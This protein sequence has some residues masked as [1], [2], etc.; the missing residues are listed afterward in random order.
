MTDQTMFD[1]K[2]RE[3]VKPDIDLDVLFTYH[4]PKG[5]QADR[6]QEIRAAAKT[7]AQLICDESPASRERSHAINKIQ[8][9]VMWANAGIARNESHE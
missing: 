9:A 1:P 3:H 4:A 7:F 2:E 6:Y 8:E 5:D